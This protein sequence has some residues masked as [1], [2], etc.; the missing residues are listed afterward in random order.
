MLIETY[1]EY[2]ID[3]DEIWDNNYN[4]LKKF[5]EKNKKRPNSNSKNVAEKKLG[6]WLQNQNTNYLKEAQAMKEKEKRDLW[7]KFNEDYKEYILNKDELWYDTYD[8]LIQFFDSNKKRPS[9]Q[10]KN[11]LE[12]KLEKWIGTQKYN[13]A[14]KIKSMKDKTKCNLWD[15]LNDKYKEYLFDPDE[16]WL[17]TYNK[18]IQFFKEN[19]TR[20]KN[21]SNNE[22]EKELASWMAMQK[23]NYTKEIYS[24]KDKT[25]RNLWEEINKEYGEYLLDR[26]KTWNDTY[27]ELIK[28]FDKYKKRPNMHAKDKSEK[29]LASWLS[30]QKQNYIKNKES[31]KDDVKRNLWETLNNKYKEYLS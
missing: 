27:N 4:E 18:L 9:R 28:Y 21:N 13:Y 15:K 7:D 20:P 10:S 3:D 2:M 8:K 26:E 1:K 23:K 29:K 16:T 19:E 17:F 31:M 22:F 5:I 30:A 6:I 24:M 12:V 25:K 14:K 11:L